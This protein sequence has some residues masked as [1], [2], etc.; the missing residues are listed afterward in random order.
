MKK[1]PIPPRDPSFSLD[2]YE[3]V[4]GTVLEDYCDEDD[5]GFFHVTTRGAKVFEEG[6]LRSRKDVGAVGLGGGHTD[7]GHHVSVVVSYSRARW[8]YDAIKGLA[9]ACHKGTAVDV[10]KLVL[11]WTG[12]PGDNWNNVFDDE[13][14][15]GATW[16]V[17]LLQTIYGMGLTNVGDKYDLTTGSGWRALLAEQG[18]TLNEEYRSPRQRYKLA[19]YLEDRLEALFYIPE[20]WD[21]GI[22]V[23]LVGFTAQPADFLKIDPDDVTIVQVAL[24]ETVGHVADIPRECELR[25]PPADI[26][27]VAVGVEDPT[28]RLL[29]SPRF[30]NDED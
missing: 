18:D 3:W 6:R 8:L 15:D 28:K 13:P 21:D 22:C 11:D 19:Q 24:R 9:R 23:P 10:V 7:P 1:N 27:I 17:D 4:A 12:F 30:D 5:A 2:P 26:Q 20:G 14:E 16:P 25:L 29:V